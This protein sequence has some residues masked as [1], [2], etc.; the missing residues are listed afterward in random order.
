MNFST[1]PPNDSISRR[2]RSWYGVEHRADVF[3][4][5]PLGP[6]GEAD[7]IDEDDGDDPPLVAAA[8]PADRQR[9]RTRGRSGRPRGSPARNSST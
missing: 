2:T 4:V 1:T 9:G 7:E 3:G 5:E 6:R 8:G